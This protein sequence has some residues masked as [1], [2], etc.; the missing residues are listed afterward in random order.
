[1]KNGDY[2]V[3]SE[4]RCKGTNSCSDTDPC[5]EA[6]TADRFYTATDRMHR[7]LVLLQ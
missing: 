7:T 1:M 4:F 3:R 2:H 5:L 6:Y